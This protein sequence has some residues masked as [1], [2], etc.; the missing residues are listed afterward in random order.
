MKKIEAFITTEKPDSALSA[1][2]AIGMQATFYESNGMGKG[3]K[4]K[5]SYGRGEAGTTKMPH[6]ERL[7]L[8][9]MVE[10]N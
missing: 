7:T 4:Y 1:L 9:T 5:L 3:E 2:D 8:L 10:E 6:S